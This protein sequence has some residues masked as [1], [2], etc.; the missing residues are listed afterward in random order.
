[1]IQ[2]SYS[3]DTTVLNSRNEILENNLKENNFSRD[4]IRYLGGYYA[5]AGKGIASKNHSA[6]RQKVTI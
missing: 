4:N 5:T 1:M 2:N 3:I 6:G